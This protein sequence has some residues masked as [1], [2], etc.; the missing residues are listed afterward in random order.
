MAFV[1]WRGNCAD[2]LATVYEEGRSRQVR[3]A[4]LGGAYTVVPEIRE[5]VGRR[6]PH[7]RVDWNAIDRALAVGPPREQ[8]AT[9]AGVPNDR[10]EWL[11]LERRL[12][13][14]A[15]LAA[16]RGPQEAHRLTAAADLLAHWRSSRPYFPM[17]EPAPGWDQGLPPPP[18]EAGSPPV[19]PQPPGH[20]PQGTD[21]LGANDPPAPDAS[22]PMHL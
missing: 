10:L 22:K 12:R 11:E 14:W 17:A 13:Y 15:A 20:H 6:F 8:A 16:P 1:R 18:S 9:A 3:L 2:L 21:G 5:E 4:G 7:L 19:T